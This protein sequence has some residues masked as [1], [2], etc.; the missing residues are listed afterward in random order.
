M[1]RTLRDSEKPALI[2]ISVESLKDHPYPVAVFPR[3]QQAIIVGKSTEQN[4]SFEFPTAPLNPEQTRRCRMLQRHGFTVVEF[5]DDEHFFSW[6]QAKWQESMIIK[7]MDKVASL[8]PE[9]EETKNLST[10]DPNFARAVLG[11]AARV[12]P[13]QLGMVELKHVLSPEPGSEALFI[14]IDALD[15]D[16]FIEAKA[17]RSAVDNGIQDVAYIKATR[18]G[19][20]H[21]SED[22]SQSRPQKHEKGDEATR[23]TAEVLSILIASPSDVAE[24][25]DVVEKVILN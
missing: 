22:K 8:Y 25:R 21:L 6:N 12:F 9:D 10:Y 7:A 13:K 1:H 23:H 20:D 4:Y 5:S 11:V 14:A 24:E 16:G 3:P 2:A 19:R 15:A 18:T 17:T